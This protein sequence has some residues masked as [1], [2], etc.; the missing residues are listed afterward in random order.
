MTDLPAEMRIRRL[1]W[2]GVEL[3]VDGALLLVDLMEDASPLAP[4]VGEPHTALP[5]PSR[6]GAAVGALATHLHADHADPPALAQALASDAPVLR[7]AP[8]AGEGL[9]TIGMA[10]AEAGLA[11]LLPGRARAVEPWE[12]VTLGPFTISAVPAVDGFGDPQVS[13]V[14]EGGG[15]R[16]FHGGD[17]LFHGSWWLIAMRH[18]PFDVAFLPV[19]GPTV[20]LPHR[21]PASPLPAAMD[22]VQA[23]AAAAILGAR[24][25]V[26][27]HYD[28]LHRSPE[29]VQ[30]DRPPER[31]R[32]AAARAGTPVAILEPGARVAP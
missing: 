6:G 31:F 17:T 24:L 20:S 2:A 12:T 25:A 5:A 21:Q 19:N 18:G 30:V 1:G 11:D 8:A 16:V 28:A 22:P 7:P 27:I 29:Y 4:W 23:A 26:P 9:E 32:A 13:W 15:R 14:V 10:H 3:E